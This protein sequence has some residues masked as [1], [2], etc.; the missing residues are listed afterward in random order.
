[1]L[2]VDYARWHGPGARHAGSPARVRSR[3]GAASRGARAT[4]K[5]SRWRPAR[6]RF[7]CWIEQRLPEA[8]ARF[9]ELVELAAGDAARSA[10]RPWATARWRSRS[11]TEPSLHAW[12]ATLR[13][14]GGRRRTSRCSLAAEQASLEL[15][16]IVHLFTA[17]AARR[18]AAMRRERPRTPARS[19]LCAS[20]WMSVMHGRMADVGS[21]DGAPARSRVGP[22]GGGARARSWPTMRSHVGSASGWRRW[23]WT[24]SPRRCSARATSP[25]RRPERA[26][27]ASSH[28]RAT[29][30]WAGGRCSSRASSRAPAAPVRAR[31]WSSSSRSRSPTSR[32]RARGRWFPLLHEARAELERACGD[33]AA[34]ERELREAQRL[35][36]EMGATGHAERLA[37]ELAP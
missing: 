37:R 27:H 28:A 34:A 8:R 20:A 19:S 6:S 23:R 17:L 1:M 12:S 31:R 2:R 35:Y 16:A 3:G 21:R 5:R 15:S 24:G 33:A 36:A 26:R 7:G 22:G 25:R 11:P 10:R 18:R 29:L 13:R 14:G 32:R 9:D 4:A 30:G